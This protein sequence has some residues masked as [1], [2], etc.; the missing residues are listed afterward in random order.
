MTVYYFTVASKQFLL[1]EEPVEEILRERLYFYQ[2]NNIPVDFWLTQNSSI[3]GMPELSSIKSSVKSDLAAII[4]TNPH[5]INWLKLRLQYV[6]T[7]T[8]NVDN[9]YE[10]LQFLR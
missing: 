1:E 8:F 4:S 3:L 2:K 7:G 10:L 6:F 9:N 5:F